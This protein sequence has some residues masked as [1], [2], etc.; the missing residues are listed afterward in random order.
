[1]NHAS[2]CVIEEL[3]ILSE[4]LMRK[5]SEAETG[6]MESHLQDLMLARVL[7]QA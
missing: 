4:M 6:V 1:M 5:G 7:P 3:S 2:A